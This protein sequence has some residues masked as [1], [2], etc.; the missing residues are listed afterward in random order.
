MTDDNDRSQTEGQEGIDRETERRNRENET[1]QQGNP[2]ETGETGTPPS[3]Q[4]RPSSAFGQQGQSAGGNATVSERTGQTG[5]QSATGEA[6][7]TAAFGQQG[8]QGGS[9]FVGPSSDPSSD[10]LTKSE[11]D[12]DFAAEGQG[13]QDNDAGSADI[14]TGQPQDESDDSTPTGK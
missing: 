12:Q 4:D 2:P 10:Y 11:Q 13:A 9:S 6:T 7:A 3:G 8:G 1:G 5:G 14:E